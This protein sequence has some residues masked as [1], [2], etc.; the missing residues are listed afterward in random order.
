[1]T[2]YPYATSSKAFSCDPSGFLPHKNLSKLLRGY[3]F[4]AF[5]TFKWKSLGH[6]FPIKI[7]YFPHRI[8]LEEASKENSNSDF[9]TKMQVDHP[10][11]IHSMSVLERGTSKDHNHPQFQVI[12]PVTSWVSAY[13]IQTNYFQSGMCTNGFTGVQEEMWNSH[14]S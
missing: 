8:A 3:L 1:M 13:T 11:Y 5:S 4:Y 14:L 12:C 2:L 6:S 9:Y 7:M 10:S